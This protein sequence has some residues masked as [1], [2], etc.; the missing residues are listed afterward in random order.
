MGIGIC[1][2]SARDS[3]NSLIFGD[4]HY[5]GNIIF[6]EIN[7]KF[8][9][10]NLELNINENDP[11]QKCIESIK[12]IE[13]NRKEIAKEFEN[14]LYDTGACVLA[15]PTMERGLTTYIVFLIAQIIRCSKE[16][17]NIFDI[18]DF[19]IKK[20]ILI[21]IDPPSINLNRESLREIKNKYNFDF[22]KNTFLI[23]GKNSIIK[24]L[25][26]IP[27]ARDIFNEQI[28]LIKEL[29]MEINNA[30][31]FNNIQILLDSLNFLFSFISE[32]I[33]G[34]A[35]IQSKLFNPEKFKLLFNIAKKAAERKIEDPKEIALFY[36]KGDNCGKIENWKENI[37][38]KKIKLDKY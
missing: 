7:I 24:F 10:E 31:I 27:K 32:V 18:D 38:Y 11:L 36:S 14:F 19:S 16:T 20:L 3:N 30:Y 33:K 37:T 26:T 35:E 28:K 5:Q 15:H 13:N 4:D 23:N 12:N 21:N 17:N 6:K 29:I 22:D 1:C 2:C 34:V 25:S 8:R 9:F